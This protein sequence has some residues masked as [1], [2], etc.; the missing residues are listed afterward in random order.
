MERV[1]NPDQDET[2]L[3]AIAALRKR[4]ERLGLTV[5]QIAA[6]INWREAD[7]AE[8][9]DGHGDD[10]RNQFYHDW[11]DRL[12]RMPADKLDANRRRT[13]DGGRFTP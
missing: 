7:V 10:I 6:G 9:E 12:E 8:V 4:R 1:P 13:D 3:E 11:L 2:G 5:R